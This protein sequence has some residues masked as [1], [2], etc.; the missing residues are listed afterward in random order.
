MDFI[1]LALS[2]QSLCCILKI[3]LL[4]GLCEFCASQRTINIFYC[5]TYN[6]LAKRKRG[7]GDL[8]LPGKYWLEIPH[9]FRGKI[10]QAPE[11]Q[12]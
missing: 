10:S 8:L 12:G 9:F 3:F 1:Y 11:N 7:I 2:S 6:E 5:R 4:C